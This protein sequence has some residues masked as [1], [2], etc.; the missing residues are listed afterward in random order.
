MPI[1]H[2]HQRYSEGV[3]KRSLGRKKRFYT[4]IGLLVPRFVIRPIDFV[5]IWHLGASVHVSSRLKLNFLQI[6]LDHRNLICLECWNVGM[7]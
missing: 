5:D 2:F 7:I 3:V 1:H 6:F 4:V